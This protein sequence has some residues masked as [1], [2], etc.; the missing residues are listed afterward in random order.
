M[1]HK[2]EKKKKKGSQR[3]RYDSFFD[4]PDIIRKISTRQF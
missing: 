1:W 4:T 2:K 3:T